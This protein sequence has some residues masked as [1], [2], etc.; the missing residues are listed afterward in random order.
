MRAG[1][2]AAQPKKRGREEAGSARDAESMGAPGRSSNVGP[3]GP[4]VLADAGMVL[5][6]PSTLHLLIHH[7]RSASPC[8]P[9]GLYTG[10]L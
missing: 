6:D 8:F 4:R 10:L 1:K 7:V 5:R 3:E 2:R 9:G